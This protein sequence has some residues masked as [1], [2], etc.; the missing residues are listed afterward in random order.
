MFLNGFEI[1]GIKGGFLRSPFNL[2]ELGNSNFF[3]TISKIFLV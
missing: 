3:L 1:Y 2:V